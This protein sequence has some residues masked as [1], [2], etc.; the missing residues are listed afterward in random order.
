[1]VHTGR[2]FLNDYYGVYY[3][4]LRLSPPSSV[5]PASNNAKR[6]EAT[7]LAPYPGIPVY[8]YNI[9]SYQSLI[10]GIKAVDMKEK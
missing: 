9:W 10:I 7:R 4:P 5:L 1:M 2:G 3:S 8:H 6:K